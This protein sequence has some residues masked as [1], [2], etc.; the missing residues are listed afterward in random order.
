MDSSQKVKRSKGQKVKKLKALMS[1]NTYSVPL[2]FWL[3]SLEDVV[4]QLRNT[5]PIFWLSG[6]STF[7]PSGFPVVRSSVSPFTNC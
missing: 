5:E 2:S 1:K 7:L 6:L 4:P 3:T